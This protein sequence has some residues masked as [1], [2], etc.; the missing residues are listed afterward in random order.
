MPDQNWAAPFNEA[1]A[2]AEARKQQ[3]VAEAHDAFKKA[4]RRAWEQRNADYQAAED[5]FNAVKALDASDPAFIEANDAY[6]RAKEPA[7]LAPARKTLAEAI[8]Q[9][10]DEY[11]SAVRRIASQHD[12]TVH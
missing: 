8:K 4:E 2:Q 10:D 7:S 12:V 5:A 1:K 6:Q 9:A 11:N 3:A